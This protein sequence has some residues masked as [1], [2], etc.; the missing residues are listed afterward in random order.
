MK[1]F[2]KCFILI[3][4][5]TIIDSLNVFASDIV[6]KIL[7]L[8]HKDKV[9]I[10]QKKEKINLYLKNLFFKIK[11][12]KKEKYYFSY[13]SYFANSKI[14]NYKNYK[15]FSAYDFYKNLN[16]DN[17][18]LKNFKLRSFIGWFCF[19][20]PVN[21]KFWIF[22]KDFFIFPSWFYSYK[23]NNIS[24]FSFYKFYDDKSLLFSKKII[25]LKKRIKNKFDKYSRLKLKNKYSRLENKKK[26][27]F[28][29][30][31]LSFLK[32]L[33]ISISN[34]RFF[35]VN[36]LLKKQYKKN[37]I[38]YKKN[39]ILHKRFSFF[40]KH[41]LEII[42]RK[43]LNVRNIG[44]WSLFYSILFI[45]NFKNNR[46]IYSKIYNNIIK[47][48]FFNNLISDLFYIKL[49]RRNLF[50]KTINSIFYS[51]LYFIDF[52]KFLLND[53]I[54]Y[55]F[56]FDFLDKSELVLIEDNYFFIEKFLILVAFELMLIKHYG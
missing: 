12:S 8:L 38:L 20:I 40:K 30:K 46:F 15:N 9:I 17:L 1:F 55:N 2:N 41:Y 49:L 4:Y 31:K 43:V 13:L 14:I 36:Y 21:Y 56:F 32:K 28:F 39:S 19:D 27:Y 44:F 26:S 5:D 37:N 42:N 16:V 45:A 7:F 51:F 50:K 22:Q 54:F 48:F 25:N 33:Y 10:V 53:F 11:K 47:K 18:N 6:N 35:F 34:N 3:F 52:K 23:L 29:K 24:F